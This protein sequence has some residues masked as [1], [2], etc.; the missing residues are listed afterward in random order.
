MHSGRNDQPDG[1]ER[2]FFGRRKGKKLRPRQARLVRDI[3]AAACA[4]SDNCRR[5][6]ICA[7]LFDSAD[8]VRMEI[9]F[10]GGEHFVSRSRAQ[11]AHWLYRRRAVR[12][13]HGESVDRDRSAGVDQCP[14]AS[15]R[16]GAIARLAAGSRRCSQWTCFIPIR[17][18][19]A[20]TG[21]GASCRTKACRRSHAFSRPAAHSALPATFPITRPGRWRGSCA[22]ATSSGRP[23]APTIGACHGRDSIPRA[24]SSRPS[25]KAGSPAI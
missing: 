14:A 12:E 19:S 3:A 24:T 18:R 16:R 13:R 23:S 4:R 20:G 25:A 11:S 5:P 17:G 22:R 15:W 21:S 1:G 9:G 7:A 10:G 6:A 2:A 8:E